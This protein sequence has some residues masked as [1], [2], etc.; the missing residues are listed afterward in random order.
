[1]DNP[2]NKFVGS[3]SRAIGNDVVSYEET[4]DS[5]KIR[6]W[7]GIS[8]DNKKLIKQLAKHWFPRKRV[9]V[10]TKTGQMTIHK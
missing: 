3:L 5:L 8:Q 9:Y 7:P 10:N 1:M 2:Y 6:L 4:A